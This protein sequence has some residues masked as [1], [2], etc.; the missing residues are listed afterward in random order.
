MKIHDWEVQFRP[1]LD[2]EPSKRA[3]QRGISHSQITEQ[4]L[5]V[6]HLGKP[7]YRKSS[8]N[9][10]F[11]Y[12]TPFNINIKKPICIISNVTKSIFNPANNTAISIGV[13]SINP[14]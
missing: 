3:L 4:P 2:L 11:V 6:I 13:D 9:K 8:T 12:N 5:G 14:G 1:S 10:I 7:I